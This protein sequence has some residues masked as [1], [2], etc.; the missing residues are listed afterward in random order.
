MV[1]NVM[2]L[3]E[4]IHRFLC[5]KF[6]IKNLGIISTDITIETLRRGTVGVAPGIFGFNLVRDYRGESDLFGRELKTISMNIAELL[7]S[8]A[9]YIMGE[10]H[11]FSPL[12]IVRGLENIEFGKSFSIESL[13]IRKEN[14]MFRNVFDY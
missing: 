3:L 1:K 8:S 9:C 12:V 14:D 4:Q 2:L 5:K 10:G 6:S 11:E 13:H 7:A